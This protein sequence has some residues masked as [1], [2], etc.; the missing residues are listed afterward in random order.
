M[1]T[2]ENLNQAW[3]N[4]LKIVTESFERALAA[5]CRVRIAVYFGDPAGHVT[6]CAMSV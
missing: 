4:T 5:G 1:Q 6:E 2:A 3:E